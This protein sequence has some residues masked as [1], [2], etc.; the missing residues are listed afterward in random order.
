M[1]TL[2]KQTIPSKT[3][4]GKVVQKHI[5]TNFYLNQMC[6]QNLAWPGG[7]YF[8]RECYQTLTEEIRLIQHQ[9]FN[10]L[11]DRKFPTGL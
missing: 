3:T 2:M 5:D 10:S 1:I 11:E 7:W 8:V 6:S 4:N 9:L